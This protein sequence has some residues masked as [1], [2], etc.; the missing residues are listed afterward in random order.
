MISR[1]RKRWL[2]AR[3]RKI[4]QGIAPARE[5]STIA[6]GFDTLADELDRDPPPATSDAATIG[7]EEKR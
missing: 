2:A 6:A 1:E 3:L 4:A 7:D 5:W